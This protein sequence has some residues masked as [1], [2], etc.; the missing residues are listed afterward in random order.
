MAT[1]FQQRG[2][3][4]SGQHQVIH[5]MVA[6]GSVSW[7]CKN[8]AGDEGQT[9]SQSHA[10]LAPPV[11]LDSTT[12]DQ[13]G[14]ALMHTLEKHLFAGLSFET[15]FDTVAAS[16]GRVS[17]HIVADSAASNLKLCW[18]LM[19]F[20]KKEGDRC[21]VLTTSHFN[22]CMLHQLSRMLTM[23]LEKQQVTASL[24]SL[25]RLNQHGPTRRKTWEALESLLQE[26]FVYQPGEVPIGTPRSS[27]EFR[28]ALLR[29][30]TGFWTWNEPTTTKEVCL[31]QLFKFFNGDLMSDN[32]THYCTGCCQNQ[33]DALNK[34]RMPNAPH[35]AY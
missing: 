35:A 33:Q 8:V 17:F 19:A 26:K 3:K 27:R 13:I 7:Q 6:T 21:G 23:C 5:N 22:A 30:L 18:K 28:L 9:E 34:A 14:A 32:L 16:F 31:E 4:H 15:W 2:T 25:T 29:L 10:F 12:A 1:G 11:Q 24:Y 20:F